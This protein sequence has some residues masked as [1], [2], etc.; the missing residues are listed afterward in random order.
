[1]S[2]DINTFIELLPKAELHLHIEGSLE[3]ELKFKLAKRNDIQLPYKS[4]EEM[5]ASYSFHDLSSFLPIYYEGMSVLLTEADFYELGMAYFEKAKSQN[6]KYAEIF[7]D[8]QAHTSRGVSFN[9]VIQGLHRAQEDAKKRFNVNSNLIMCFLRDMSA[10]YAMATLLEALPYKDWIIGVGLDSDEK[11][12]PPIKFAKVFSRAKKE[13]FH[14]TMHCDVDQENSISHLWQCMHDIQV[15]RIDHG[16]NSLED[17]KLCEEII[18]R[19]IGLTVCPISNTF[20]TGSLKASEIKL[21]LNKGM[22]VT[23]NSDDPAYFSS[24]Y[25][26]ENLLAVQQD[27]NLSREELKQLM[28]NAFTISW[29]DDEQKN[30]YLKEVK[31]YE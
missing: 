17:E 29:L 13:G 6:V 8:P 9:T 12:N 4:V 11:G 21:M 10:E 19:G 31:T 16:V 14:T 20:V 27:V 26:T 1:M 22:R 2:N 30:I 24:R 3:P 7:F 28:I 25:I 15:D 5:R 23:V 18:N